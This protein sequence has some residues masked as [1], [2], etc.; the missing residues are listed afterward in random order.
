MDERH[1]QIQLRPAPEVVRLFW[2]GG[3]LD[4]RVCHR[5]HQMSLLLQ[6]VQAVPAIRVGHIQKVDRLDVVALFPKVRR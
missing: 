3:V 6:G 2:A 4:N 5:L 1:E